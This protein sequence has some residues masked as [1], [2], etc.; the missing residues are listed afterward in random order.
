MTAA[1]ASITHPPRRRR[2]GTG[3]LGVAILGLMVLIA[4]AGPYVV[5][6]RPTELAG[7]PLEPPSAAHLLGTNGVGNDLLSQLV[8]GAQTSLIIAGLAGVGTLIVGASI[9]LAAGW[10]GG[11]IE[12][13]LMRFTDTVLVLPRLPLLIVIGAYLR[14]NLITTAAVIAFTFW[15]PTARVVRSQVLTVRSR[16][17]T[18]AAVG[19]GAGVPYLIRRHIVPDIGPVL[20]AGLVAAAGRAVAL[21]AGLAFLGLGDPART[22]WGMIMRD[23]LDFAALFYTPAWAW[24]LLPP[25][26]ALTAFLVGLTF[27]GIE[28]ESY[29]NRRLARHVGGTA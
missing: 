22:S 5:R 10:W 15:P 12:T 9:G 16:T 18:L 13:L 3:I 2:F 20:V 28:I 1:V 27:I 8:T 25:I 4:T 24:W 14:P 11:M 26:L 23:A 19:F 21:E 17:Y 29:S 6:Y 7:R